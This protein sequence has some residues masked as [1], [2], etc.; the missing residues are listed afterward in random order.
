MRILLVL[1]ALAS[2][3]LVV[4]TFGGDDS[5]QLPSLTYTELDAQI[6]LGLVES[7]QMT[8]GSTRLIVETVDGERYRAVIPPGF[9][10]QFVRGVIEAEPQIR[11][12]TLVNT[13]GPNPWLVVLNTVAPLA[14]MVILVVVILG[15]M[16]GGRISKKKFRKKT[17]HDSEG[18]K[19]VTFADVAGADEAVTEL[20]EIREFLNDA[21]RFSALGA[22][23]PKGVLLYGPPGT[24]KTLLARAVAG[25]AGVPFFTLSGSDFVEKFA[26]VGAGRVR[27]LF[28]QARKD[29]PA[30]IF[31]DEID[32]VGRHR[33]GGGGA[34]NEE[35]EQT[36]N[37]LLVEMDGF[38]V[39]SGVIFI[40]ATNRPDILD[41]ALL[42]PGRFDRQ[43][44]VDIPDINGRRQIAAVHAE[45]KPLAPGVSIETIARRTPG[46]TGA[47][48]ANLLN[49][50]ALLSAR[51][52]LTHISQ[53]E[54]DDALDRVIAGPEKANTLSEKERHTIAYHEAGH[55]LV[56]H[57]LPNCDPIHKVSIIARGKALG[58]T[59][60]LPERDRVMKTQSELC[61]EMAMLLGGRVAEE[62]IFRDP[63]TGASNDI[64][65]VTAIARSMVTE[66]GMSALGPQRFGRSG[67]EVYAPTHD[68]NY[69]DDVAMRI[70]EATHQLIDRAAA[71][72]RE[73][74]SLHRPVLDKI[75]DALIEHETIGHKELD[76]LFTDL[77]PVTFRREDFTPPLRQE[78]LDLR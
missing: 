75:A 38:D 6:D 12:D 45:G 62:L 51:R 54:L 77:G 63:T 71:E 48:I 73:V 2:C 7:V 35:R 34:G 66:Y 37:Q 76:V 25:E 16:G 18:S 1:L 19:E 32:A 61:D 60:A 8:Q 53:A 31:V 20:T 65:R 55:A 70:D 10:E 5:P 39:S 58:W 41:K 14:L 33:G 30:I 42:R 13:S 44:A 15:R 56:G 72:A 57:L 67:G 11:L 22:K 50:A 68:A 43:I 27:D 46:F 69:S 52:N 21:D 3:L 24:G 28:D 26:G 40:A 47:D 4:Q 74:L 64:E 78:V 9:A 17:L 23:I 59:L 49:E 36:L 29:A